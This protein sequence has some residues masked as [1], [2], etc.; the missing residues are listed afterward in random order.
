[1]SDAGVAALMADSACDAAYL[2]VIINLA[3]IGDKRFADE[4]AKE[5]EGIRKR[6]KKRSK[7]IVKKVIAKLTG[8]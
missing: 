2:N 4:T 7:R 5:A 3:N 1:V 8:V 6:A